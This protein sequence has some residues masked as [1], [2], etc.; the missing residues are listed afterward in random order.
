MLSSMVAIFLF[1]MVG[2]LFFMGVSIYNGL[3]SLRAQVERAWSNI[4]VILKQRFDELPQ[5]IQVVEQY[6][7]Y[8]A[9]I[10]EKIADARTRYG[11]S[12]TVGE[13]IQASNEIS[14]ALRGVMAIGEAYP[15]LKA[16]EQ[17]N[18]L[19]GRISS[20]ESTI[21]D[22][23]ETYNDAV[24][25]FNTRIEQFP[26]LFAARFLGYDRQDLFVVSEKEKVVP[27]LKMNLPKFGSKSA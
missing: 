12:N 18:Q 24:T 16:N 13:K 6:A 15:E 7:H 9:G 8:E 22:R 27:N 1:I 21:A 23:R 17:F 11:S 2:V 4:D 25:N 19:Q 10:L 3:V 14:M 20:L 5:I 26:D